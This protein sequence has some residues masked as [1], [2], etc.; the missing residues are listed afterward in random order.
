MPKNFNDELYKSMMAN[1]KGGQVLFP[2]SQ[3]DNS[4]AD[5]MLS[6]FNHLTVNDDLQDKICDDYDILLRKLNS[7]IEAQPA[8]NQPPAEYVEIDNRI[9]INIVS[10]NQFLEYIAQKSLKKYYFAFQTSGHHCTYILHTTRTI[11]SFSVP[12]PDFC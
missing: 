3:G 5:D 11:T 1:K 4:L 10:S 9:S 8:V 2:K 6:E 12:T 7:I